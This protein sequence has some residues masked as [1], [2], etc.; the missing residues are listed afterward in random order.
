MKKQY[1]LF[2]FPRQGTDFFMDCL[3]SSNSNL[4]Y[5][6]E[7]FNPICAVPK[8]TKKISEAFG[9]ENNYKKI[10]F[11]NED[12]LEGVYSDTW[13]L[14]NFNITKEVFSFSKIYFFKK[15]FELF[16]L[17]RS[18]RNTF[19]TS[20]PDF[21]LPIFNSFIEENYFHFEVKNEIKNYLKTFFFNNIEKQVLSHI[22]CWFLQFHEIQKSEIKL[23][24]YYPLMSLEKDGLDEYL[25]KN[26]P[27]EL[28]NKALSESI[29]KKRNKEIQ[30]KRYCDY[31]D[32]NVESTC[33]NFIKFLE[34]LNTGLE[35]KYWDMLV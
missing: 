1:M 15:H 35:D 3:I 4:K 14:E 24:Q 5:Y 32:L 18:R 13:K 34:K 33:L 9:S 20:R 22:F 26:I 12:L 2:S 17:Y 28:Y 8:Y 21:I 27:E 31:K 6:R 19:P 30:P 29:I 23:I 11:Y 25:N 7:F 16:A 10:F